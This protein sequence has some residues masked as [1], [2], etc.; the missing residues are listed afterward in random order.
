MAPRICARLSAW[1]RPVCALTGD[2]SIQGR[3]ATVM[4]KTYFDL[5]SGNLVQDWSNTG[6]ITTNDD[7]SGVP[8]I[9]GYLGQDLTATTAVD[10][11]NVTGDSTVA[12]DLDVI[13]NQSNTAITNGGV[14]EFDGIANP[15]VALQGSGTA[16][17]PY[18]IFYLNAS[19][20][21]NVR[22]QFNARD[23]DGTAD[24][25]VQPLNVQYR[26]GESGPWANVPGGHFS[27][28]T[29]GPSQATQVTAV[30]VTL[31]ANANNQAQVQ[32]RI[33]T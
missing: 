3:R 8:S 1:R 33:M 2:A 4:S 10:P 31:P 21:Q 7:W 30:D 12:N 32:V 6:L 13:A 28:V 17:A 14:A 26:I 19:G 15:T 18:L 16:D 24:N 23:I 25:A 20:R 29:S 27:D 9:E 22:V 5:S 11:G